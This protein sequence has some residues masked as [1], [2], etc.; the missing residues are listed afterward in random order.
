MSNASDVILEVNSTIGQI[1]LSGEMELDEPLDVWVV[2]PSKYPLSAI[3]LASRHVMCGALFSQ[4]AG[5]NHCGFAE[6]S[7]RMS[8]PADIYRRRVFEGLKDSEIGSIDLESASHGL[9]EA[10]GLGLH[11]AK[12]MKAHGATVGLA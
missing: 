9:I 3:E 10:I 4:I 11:L 8:V 6:H 12:R 7:A 1:L 2:N 5:L